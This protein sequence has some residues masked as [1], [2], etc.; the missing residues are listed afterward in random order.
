MAECETDENNTS[1]MSDANLLFTTATCPNCKISY[2]VLD[3]AGFKYEKILAPEH[4]DLVDQFA[5]KQV[6]TLVVI[7]NGQ[8]NKYIGVS[9][10]KKMLKV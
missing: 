8:V 6:P 7:K 9:E 2:S 4:L 5:V 1:S 10:I 3:K